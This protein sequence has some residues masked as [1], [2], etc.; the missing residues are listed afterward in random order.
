MGFS[1]VFFLYFWKKATFFRCSLFAGEFAEVGLRLLFIC[2]VMAWYNPSIK[3]LLKIDWN[4]TFVFTF[5]REPYARFLSGCNFKKISPAELFLQYYKE[6]LVPTICAEQQNMDGSNKTSTT[7]TIN[8]K[9]CVQKVMTW[10]FRQKKQ[11]LDLYQIIYIG[12]TNEQR[13]TKKKIGNLL[14]P[15]IELYQFKQKQH[16]EFFEQFL[17]MVKSQ[18]IYTTTTVPPQSTFFNQTPHALLKLSSTY[19]E[20]FPLDVSVLVIVIGLIVLTI[21]F[22]LLN[23]RKISTKG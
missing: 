15:D 1:V 10:G 8:H 18:P 11:S 20:T 12:R 23:C 17:Q 22:K 3:A 13:N 5:I 4:N 16:N 6:S 19:S 21:L 9:D 2:V 7:I 14:M